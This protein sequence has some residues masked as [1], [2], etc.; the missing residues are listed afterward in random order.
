MCKTAKINFSKNLL[1]DEATILDIDIFKWLD[2]GYAPKTRAYICYNESFLKIKLESDEKDLTI[3]ATDD[4]LKIWCDSCL[5]MF[6]MPYDDDKRYINFEF[7]PIGKMIMALRFDRDNKNSIVKKYK[8]LLSVQSEIIKDKSW[9]ITFKISFEMLKEIYGK[10]RIIKKGDIIKANFYKCGDESI[11][12]H[13]GMW[14]E[15][16]TLNP[17]FH[18]PEYFGKLILN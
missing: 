1:I 13:Y 6:L 9:S 7:N 15:V 16:K 2:N 18:R 10:D 12:E 8:P 4:D 14:S 11:F 17:D 3:N 5:E